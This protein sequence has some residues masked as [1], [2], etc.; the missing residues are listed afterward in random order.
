MTTSSRLQPTWTNVSNG[1]STPEGQQLCQII[2]KSM[3]KCTTYDP[4]NWLVGCLGY[5]GPLRQYFSLYRAVSQREGEREGKGQMRVKMPPPA[6]TTNAVGPCPTITQIVGRPSSGSYD[7]DKLSLWPFYYL[8]FK[9][10]LDLQTTW[11]GTSTLQGH[12]LCHIILKSM[13]KCISYGLD[14]LIL[15]PFYQ[16]AFKSNL[17]L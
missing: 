14:N 8:T 10:D 1:T 7:P 15:W 6:P 2:L 4:D 11:N 12:Q 3:H 9:C 17:N 16:L 13:Y 5:N